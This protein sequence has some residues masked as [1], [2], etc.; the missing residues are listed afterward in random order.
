MRVSVETTGEI[1]RKMTVAIP[2]NEVEQEIAARLKRLSKTARLPGFRPGKAPLKII[3]AKYGA[4]LFHEVAG[5]LIESSLR[6]ALTREGLHPAGGP[7]IEPKSLGRGSD[8]EYVA[9]FDVFP[10]I[11]KLDLQG[12]SI[13]RPVCEVSEADVDATLETMRQQRADWRAVQRPA[14]DGDRVRMNFHGTVEGEEFGGNTAEDYA[15]VLGEGNILAEFEQGLRGAEAGTQR[16]VSVAFPEGF[17]NEAVAGKQAEFEID[18]VEVAEAVLPPLDEAFARAFGVSD[19]SVDKMR[20][21]VRDNLAREVEDRIGRLMRERV[22]EALMEANRIELPRALVREEVQNLVQSEAS[23]RAQRGVT[24]AEKSDPG[25]FEA[26]ARRRVA[27]GLIVFEIVQAHKL[28]PDP[29]RV[30]RKVEQLAAAYQDPQAL[31]QWYYGDRKRLQQMESLVLE[32]Q[33]VETLLESAAIEDQ[34]TAL[35]GLMSRPVSTN[36]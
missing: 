1:G 26:E 2:A 33:V 30:R 17:P 31:I 34:P 29:N 9:S 15:V 18:V 28:K 27:L 35:D 21:E 6:D 24:V 8:L 5:Q 23:L 7:E 12:V 32:E 13:A 19:G 3:E 22:M 20:Q 36:I 10:E 14:A 25:K 11:K 16:R 4:Q